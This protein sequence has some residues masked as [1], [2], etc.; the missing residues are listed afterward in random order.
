MKTGGKT[1]RSDNMVLQLIELV[2]CFLDLFVTVGAT[3]EG[4]NMLT[5]DKVSLD[6]NEPKT[7]QQR[8]A[9]QLRQC[10]LSRC[11]S[12]AFRTTDYCWKHQDHASSKSEPEPEENWWEDEKD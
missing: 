10:K 2:C 6:T 8:Q 1:K 12:L 9:N 5:R 7:P 4:I 3:T 11:N